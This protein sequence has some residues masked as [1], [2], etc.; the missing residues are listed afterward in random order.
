VSDALVIVLTAVLALGVLGWAIWAIWHIAR[1]HPTRQR[2]LS[3]VLGIMAGTIQLGVVLPA[4]LMRILDPFPIWLVY[5][6]LAVC[7]TTVLAW[8]WHELEPG[9]WGRPGLLITT[10]VLLA[11]LA[12]AGIAVT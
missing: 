6:A 3:H 5:G 8:R 11:V 1:H 10:G 7:A 12:M 2:A 4:V 9:K